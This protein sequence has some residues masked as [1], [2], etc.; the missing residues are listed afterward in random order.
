MKNSE[1]K[2]LEMKDELSDIMAELSEKNLQRLLWF[3]R[4]LLK[5]NRRQLTKGVKASALSEG[6]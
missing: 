6:V 1:L 3:A 4:G 2:K 5:K